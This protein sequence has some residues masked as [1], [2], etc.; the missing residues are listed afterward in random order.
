MERNEHD[1]ISNAREGFEILDDIGFFSDSW[2][3]WASENRKGLLNGK[4]PLSPF[5]VSNTDK[6][7]DKNDQGPV[8]LSDIDPSEFKETGDEMMDNLPGDDV[9]RV[10]FY[11]D[12]VDANE[13][14][15]AYLRLPVYEQCMVANGYKK[16]ALLGN[17]ERRIKIDLA[18]GKLPNAP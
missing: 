12:L 2:F 1:C 5:T 14:D 13:E 6:R 11:D 18:R 17:L 10:Y 7:A 4:K 16:K 15:I 3:E 8:P 9:K